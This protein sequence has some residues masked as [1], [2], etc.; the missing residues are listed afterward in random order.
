MATPIQNA[1][2]VLNGLYNGTMPQTLQDRVIAAYA[3]LV[4]PG[5]TNAVIAAKFLDQLMTVVRDQVKFAERASLAAAND[6][7]LDASLKP[8]P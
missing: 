7:S 2:A 3:L 6:A 5:S 4:P 8:Q 1:I